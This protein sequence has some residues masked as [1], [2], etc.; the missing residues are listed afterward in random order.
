[1]NRVARIFRQIL[2]TQGPLSED[3]FSNPQNEWH[4]VLAK[5]NRGVSFVNDHTRTFLVG[6]V[7]LSVGISLVFAPRS[8]AS[9]AVFYPAACQGDWANPDN[10]SGAPSIDDLSPASLYTVINS[11][12][13]GTTK[14]NLTCGNFF[15]EIPSGA[16]PK[17]F[18]VKLHWSFDDGSIIHDG[19]IQNIATSESQVTV[20]SLDGSV[21]SG[22]SA[23]STDAADTSTGTTI[24]SLDGS[25]GPTSSASATSTTATPDTAS[26]TPSSGDTVTI[27]SL[28]GNPTSVSSDAPS[29][30][31]VTLPAAGS[32]STSSTPS[33]SDTSSGDASQP[34]GSPT[35]TPTPTPAL[36]P[37]PDVISAPAP[38]STPAP[39]DSGDAGSSLGALVLAGVSDPAMITSGD[40]LLDVRY[41]LDGTSWTTIGS[42]NS[43]DWQSADFTIDD[44]NVTAWSDLSKLQ[45]G[46]FYVAQDGSQTAVYIDSMEVDVNYDDAPDTVVPTV[47][48]TDPALA[49]VTP[50]KTDFTL[51]ES[52][53]FSIDDPKLSSDDI[54]GL[55]KDQKASVLDDKLGVFGDPKDSHARVATPE[56]TIT[57]TSA[58]GSS[59]TSANSS[60]LSAPI[61]PASLPVPDSTATS[62]ETSSSS[63]DVSATTATSTPST[64]ASSSASSI[65]DSTASSTPVIA[66]STPVS[67]PSPDTSAAPAST[68]TDDTSSS[69]PAPD[70]APSPSDASAPVSAPMPAPVTAPAPAP[71]ETQ[72]P[73]PVDQPAAPAP[74]S[75]T[76]PLASLAGAFAAGASAFDQPLAAKKATLSDASYMPEENSSTNGAL[77]R[78]IG[79][80][81]LWLYKSFTSASA[82]SRSLEAYVGDTPPP[83]VDAV[84]LDANGNQTTIGTSIEHVVVDGVEKDQVVV[85]KPGNMFRPGLY[86]L[87]VTLHTLEANIV[88][89]QNFSWGVLALNVD[90]STY[91]PGDTAYV[92]MGVLDNLGRTICDADMNLVITDPLGV[93]QS[94]STGAGTIARNTACG[95][96]TF[97]HTPDYSAHV[98]VGSNAGTYDITLTADTD[99]GPRTVYDSF[100]VD[101]DVSFAVVRTGPTRIYPVD[102]YPM[103]IDIT[104]TADWEG[105]VVETMPN[106]FTPSALDD[107][108]P[109]YTA[110]TK[111]DTTTLS[112][113]LSLKAGVTTTIGYKF[114]APPISPEFYLLGPLSFYNVDDDPS[115]ATPVFQEARRW[116]I[117]DD[118]VCTAT[119]SG[120]WSASTGVWSGCTGGGAPA[121][122]DTVTIN[123]GVVVTLD[124]DTPV[125]AAVTVNGTLDA[126]N[127][128][129]CG[130]GTRSCNLSATT[131][132]IGTAGTYNAGTSS[133]VTLSATTGPLMT[134]TGSGVFNAGTSTVTVTDVCPSATAVSLNTGTWTGSSNRLYNLTVSTNVTTANC[135]IALGATTEI[136][137]Q[138]NMPAPAG[139]SARQT[140]DTSTFNM[141]VGSIVLTGN[142]TTSV[143][144]ILKTNATTVT[145][146]GT[147][148]A[149]I[150]V[151]ATSCVNGSSGSCGFLNAGTSTFVIS[152]DADLT[153]TAFTGA[154]NATS[155]TFYNL[156][157]APVLTATTRTY[158][159]AAFAFTNIF[160][161]SPS[162]SGGS[163]ARTLAL[164]GSAPVGT[165]VSTFKIINGADTNTTTSLSTNITAG[166]LDIEAGGILSAGSNTITLAGIS[167]TLLTQAGT[168][169]FNGGTSTVTTTDVC[170]G[171]TALTLNTGT[172]TGANNRLNNLTLNS[173]STSFNCA[174]QLGANIEAV[175]ALSLTTSAAGN[176]TFTTLNGASTYN[177]TAGSI[178]AS[179][180]GGSTFTANGSTITLTGTGAGPLTSS[181]GT[182]STSSANFVVNGNGNITS[183][184]G[185]AM[186]INNLTFSPILSASATYTMGTVPT[187]NGNLTSNPTSSGS[188]TTLTLSGAL[189]VGTTKTF[190]VTGDTNTTTALSSN[191]SV[192]LLSVGTGGILS[193]GSTTITVT[194]ASGPL[195]TQS[196]TGVFT[197]GT[198][199]V[200]FTETVG[201]V[202]INTSGFTGANA[203]Y[204]LTFNDGAGGA[205]DQFILGANLSA[206]HLTTITAGTLT[207]STFVFATGYLNIV[208]SGTTTSRIVTSASSV[209]QLTGTSSYPVGLSALIT[210]FDGAGITSAGNLGTIEIVS[211]DSVTVFGGASS[212]FASNYL[213]D[214]SLSGSSTYTYTIGL[215]FTIVNTK[216]LT[217]NPLGSTGTLTVASPS[218]TTSFGTAGLLLVEGN[219][220]SAGATAV[221]DATGSTALTFGKLDVETGGTINAGSSTIT[222][223]SVIT[224]PALLVQGGTGVFNAGTST[225]IIN[226]ATSTSMNVNSGAW[227]GASNSLYNLTFDSSCGASCQ[228][229]LGANL[230]VTNTLSFPVTVGGGRLICGANNLNVG[231][232]NIA[233]S[234]GW[235]DST[236]TI[237]LTGTSGTLFTKGVGTTNISSASIV[238]N[239]NGSPTVFSGAESFT[240]L[241]FSPVLTSGVGNIAYTMGT[242]PTLSGS[243]TMNPSG[244][245]NSLT[246]TLAATFATI[247]AAQTVTIQATGGNASA[248]LNTSGSNFAITTGHVVIGTGGTIVGNN[249]TITLSGT[250]GTLWTQNGTFTAG[251]SL[252]T[253]LVAATGTFTGGTAANFNNVTINNTGFTA[254]LG[255]PTTVAGTLTVTNGTI[256]T[257][258]T[259]NYALTAGF[260]NLA[261]NVS[262]TKL[263][264]NASTITLNGTGA[265]TLLTRAGTTATFTVGTSTF[266][267]ASASGTP[268]IVGIATT[269]NKLWINTGASTAPA[270]N[271]ANPATEIKLGASVTVSATTGTQDF[272]IQ[273]GTLDLGAVATLASTVN[274]IGTSTG[275]FAMGANSKLLVNAT[276]TSGIASGCGQGSNF[277]AYTGSWPATS[278]FSL[279]PASTV[280]YYHSDSSNSSTQKMCNIPT[281]GN[282][283]VTPVQN[284]TQNVANYVFMS[285]T[286][287]I[288]GNFVFSPIWNTGH[289]TQFNQL[290]FG[291]T[292]SVT[293]VTVAGSA[294]IDGTAGSDPC[295]SSACHEDVIFG[296]NSFS[297][298]T[299]NFTVTGAL[300]NGHAS[301]PSLMDI[302]T[303][304]NS[305]V[306][307]TGNTINITAGGGWSNYA[308]WGNGLNN[309]MNITD[310]GSWTQN[311]TFTSTAS[312]TPGTVTLNGATTAAVGGTG[313]KTFYNFTVNPAFVG[314]PTISNASPAVVS[315]LSHGFSVGDSLYF[316]TT[317]ALPSGITAN[318]T[319]YVISAGYTANSFEISTSPGGAAVNTSTP[320]SGVHSLFRG[321]N[322]TKEIDFTHGQTFTVSNLLNLTGHGGNLVKLF[323]DSGGSTWTLVPPTTAN[324]TAVFADVK[325]SFCN[326]NSGGSNQ[327]NATSSTDDGNNSLASSPPGCWQFGLPYI[328]FTLSTNAV[329]F[330]ALSLAASK[331]GTPG[332]GTGG[333]FADTSDNSTSQQATVATSAGNGYTLYVQGSSLTNGTYI[334]T[335]MSSPA[336]PN[337]GHEQFGIYIDASGG[338]GTVTSPYNNGPTNFVYTASSSTP[339][340]VASLGSASLRT[341]T[342]Y[343]HYLANISGVT[344]VAGY[345]TTLTYIAVPNF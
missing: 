315:L 15:G 126:S 144:S 200:T 63:D 324:N 333:S 251:T 159:N 69:A 91:H 14:G 250:T 38:A 106:V 259:G 334:I 94:Y 30:T 246:Y 326:N 95:P 174:W 89:E 111:G 283:S 70:A 142:N 58:P 261:T 100:Q 28:D 160:Q 190:T 92:Q 7:I 109:A 107:T 88:S 337:P 86:T 249:S 104:P 79:G 148:G 276:S 151:G 238:V 42:V 147:S 145:V 66:S 265:G 82:L 158:T 35:P 163:T 308:T 26:S 127:A 303:E 62:T 101:P 164:A 305:G 239:G 124:I 212:T 72:A 61:G 224:S 316:T 13:L 307:V 189:T 57:D 193:P 252:V 236:G 281:Y 157:F 344:P 342:Y 169:V 291:D 90:Q 5:I 272:Y 244:S 268:S 135:V 77:A 93:S 17:A 225:I 330:G 11:A 81:K 166:F 20:P 179:T 146:T 322:V 183:I 306:G 162:T 137:N 194:G 75:D 186:T 192:G 102:A 52:P 123:S 112:W 196:G 227:T 9:M 221:F 41:T 168:G 167:G 220:A 71:T 59:V 202:T 223:S 98:P 187:I 64:D 319:Y 304:T 327:I 83:E 12:V 18:S 226:Q 125:V 201:N 273:S 185:K 295:T 294:S 67:A 153:A 120:N 10:A 310:G 289:F 284:S 48:V 214:P 233:I 87:Q 343:V 122:G 2:E 96:N 175:G 195:L 267:I 44:P 266:V 245:A 99:N 54:A 176:Q 301:M 216:S 154:A 108:Y 131:V 6:L 263:L 213:M 320:G 119:A 302:Q 110:S 31:T 23:S 80:T 311:G 172:W 325:D 197:A 21:V 290:Q 293:N 336:L 97:I 76:P 205:S 116:Q 140:L 257:S 161:A 85:D 121:T 139:S 338:S 254:P 24:P 314:Y 287:T 138:L 156:T 181:T 68:T 128:T 170:T 130:G 188:P 65:P 78:V 56:P 103:Q 40:A 141:T 230:T 235:L 279:D 242:M 136:A 129:A 297:G 117:A 280:V 184:F 260:I 232:I 113:N 45:I 329:D 264:C 47:K 173:N 73:A 4:R 203:L 53:T 255:A 60:A 50:E 331:Y 8:L 335:P 292:S 231:S 228:F 39:S 105:T 345:S 318:T 300:N 209:V 288:A 149:L 29:D 206:T 152:Q 278:N 150:T 258:S 313:T 253:S 133:T 269:F 237:T 180:S 43:S 218:G 204:N 247:A 171:T 22:T 3:V 84:V 74:S 55:V 285:G 262:T 217:I 309:T 208:A 132:S 256:D 339:V 341:T 182:W 207:P 134:Q 32:P 241:T 215:P 27:P 277:P 328:N 34:S 323:S 282:L 33:S 16:T 271:S 51:D 286:T 298:T 178:S 1:M 296:S 191:Y 211:L 177:V 222:L 37:A 275:Q 115:T 198:S 229:S 36:T 332:T 49:I 340:S 155:L 234:G 143:E 165:S 274:L 199:T 210:E 248:I 240:N 321:N 19:T 270:T 312:L 25:A 219:S 118:S 243:F 317:S 46:L 299:T 114:L